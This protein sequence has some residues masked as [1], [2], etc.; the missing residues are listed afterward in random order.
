LSG[1]A[2]LQSVSIFG[3]EKGAIEPASIPLQRWALGLG[4]APSRL[5]ASLLTRASETIATDASKIPCDLEKIQ[6][7]D[8]KL[9][10]S[11]EPLH[12]KGAIPS[13]ILCA[14]CV[15]IGS[16]VFS[17]PKKQVWLFGALTLAGLSIA[18]FGI[19]GAISYQSVN[20]LGLTSGNSFATFVSKNSA[21]G[22][23]NVCLAGCLGL[24][25]WTLLNTRRQNNDMRYRFPDSNL[26]SR[27]R[28]ITED[29]LSDLNTPQIASMLC[30]I[31]IAA[32]L[33]ISLCRGAAVSAVGA[34]VAAAVVANLKSEFKGGWVTAVAILFACIACLIGL[35]LD[36]QAYTRLESISE[37]D[38][39]GEFRQ[40]RGY[41]WTMAWNASQYFGWA[42]SGLGTFHFAYLPFQQPS[43]NTWFYHAE[44]LYAQC[45]VELGYFGL[46]VLVISLIVAIVNF[47][48]QVPN[49]DWRMVLPAKLAG[50][51]LLFSQ[52][53]H[54]FVDFA[55][56]LPSLFVPA[57]LLFGSVQG[58][59]RAAAHLPATGQSKTSSLSVPTE[60]AK[61]V[62]PASLRK[63][64]KGVAG[65]F[66]SLVGGLAIFFSLDA[67]R[68]LSTSEAMNYWVKTEDKK[69]ITDQLPNRT[70]DLAKIWSA[71]ECEL[72]DNPNAMR[73]FADA[74][75]FD[76]RM[77]QLIAQ[78]SK[79][80][81]VDAWANTS[82][83][84]LQ[85]ALDA[86]EN[87]FKKDMIVELVGGQKAIDGLSAAA[88]WYALGQLKSP[89]DWRLGWGRC[90]S[91][92][93]CERAKM[94]QLLSAENQLAR[95]SSQQL[96]AATMLFRQQLDKASQETI[97]QQAMKSN[98]A[99][100]F[101]VSK[102]LANER[103]DID[104]PVSIF[105]KRFDV[106]QG[107]ALQTFTKDKFPIT[108]R[109]L[110]EK[111]IDLVGSSMMTASRR[112]LWLADAANALGDHDGE[113]THLKT[114]SRYEPSNIK[115][116]CRLANVFLDYRDA[117]SA[118]ELLQQARRLDPSHSDVKLL[119][120]RIVNFP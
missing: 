48:K 119:S 120:E 118:R 66:L 110:W 21:G 93:K 34:L 105:P 2:A 17:E 102:L 64:R 57:C 58:L 52:S 117:K 26:L 10:W 98:P 35:Q 1:F 18:F 116:M 104:I 97:L 53:L 84:L 29:L 76:F 22:Y 32:A 112:E 81:M 101:G 68:S 80:P 83:L 82:P 89:L 3:W 115:L 70:H 4:E 43:S 60:V 86:K 31:T 51:Y 103:N 9:A 73:S 42:G 23:F 49:D 92:T 63:G 27:I 95:H 44:S 46:S 5:E 19:L 15:W 65:C 61:I 14:F 6:P 107:L 54:S 25:A 47:Q 36:D 77:N 45:A 69:P 79:S 113:I 72:T 8:R 114:A 56:I 99:V 38:I 67:V 106:L 87:R 74:L 30:L 50:A 78:A 91:N 71:G 85:L 88:D 37:I 24:L 94:A 111:A 108:N 33:T 7:Q 62:N 90:L 109:L 100:S 39:E 13:L 11:V 96:F 12:T 16:M 28:G 20:F 40:G 75:V 59:L 41:I 55:I